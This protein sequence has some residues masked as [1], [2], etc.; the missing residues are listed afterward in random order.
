MESTNQKPTPL[1]Y[2]IPDAADMLGIG[3]SKLYKLLDE[4]SLP[5]VSIGRR[6]LIAHADL[7]AFVDMLRGIG[8][9]L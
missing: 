5:T 7:V 8:T 1:A 6:R 2:S 4:G 9:T 3:R